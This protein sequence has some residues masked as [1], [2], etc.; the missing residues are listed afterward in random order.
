[1]N[2]LIVE[3]DP[4]SLKLAS[5]VLE[6]ASHVVMTATTAD[7]AILSIKTH[8][9]DAIILDL[10]LPGVRGLA[11]A[12]QCREDDATRD[13]PIIAV[14]A[15][16]QNFEKDEAIDAGCDGFLLKPINTRTFAQEVAEIVAAKAKSSE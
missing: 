1:M 13:I 9:P 15:F 7:Q 14:T 8:K 4:A 5:H 11:V 6:A 2:I 12:R 10:H 3:N 16:A